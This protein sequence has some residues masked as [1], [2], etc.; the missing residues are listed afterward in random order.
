MERGHDRDE[1]PVGHE[2]ED[3]IERDVGQVGPVG[4]LAEVRQVTVSLVAVSVLHDHLSIGGDE[5]GD[6]YGERVGG[7]ILFREGEIGAVGLFRSGFVV[8]AQ[9]V[10][11]IQVVYIQ[12]HHVAVGQEGAAIISLEVVH[13]E[14]LVIDDEYLFPFPVNDVTDDGGIFFR[15]LSPSADTSLQ[16]LPLS[17]EQEDFADTATSDGDAV[18][19]DHGSV[20]VGKCAVGGCQRDIFNVGDVLQPDFFGRIIFGDID[21]NQ[22]RLLLVACLFTGADGCRD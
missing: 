22:L 12:H 6:F 15:S 1:R 2:G 7:T 14:V 8:A 18:V 13:F 11:R 16:R 4:T 9:Q 21:N 3:G 19:R 5:T 17:V 10:I 20:E